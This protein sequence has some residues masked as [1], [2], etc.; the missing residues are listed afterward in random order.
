VSTIFSSGCGFV[1]SPSRFVGTGV[2][3]RIGPRP[4]HALLERG[5]AI[6][7]SMI[8]RNHSSRLAA[9][10]PHGVKT[11]HSMY[12]APALLFVASVPPSGA[13]TNGAVPPG[14]GTA[15]DRSARSGRAAA[16]RPPAPRIRVGAR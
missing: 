15:P 5:W 13:N 9:L 2:A 4:F 10:L 1:S 14:S 7:S 3:P 12:W 11:P 16:L 8:P 6:T